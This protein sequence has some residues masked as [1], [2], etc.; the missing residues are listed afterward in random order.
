MQSSL[1]SLLHCTQDRQDPIDNEKIGI[2]VIKFL[3]KKLITL[4][5]AES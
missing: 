4:Q 2:T 5:T 3:Q 1:S